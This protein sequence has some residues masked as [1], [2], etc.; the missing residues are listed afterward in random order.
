[1]AERYR[2]RLSGPILDRIDL[3]VPVPRLSAE[4]LAS[5]AP[6]EASADIRER[7]TKARQRQKARF[8][9]ATR[10]NA[11]LSNRELDYFLRAS[12]DAERFLLSS[13]DRL[14]LSSRAFFRIKKVARTIADLASSDTVTPEHVAEAVGYRER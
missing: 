14:K 12:P 7:V 13:V 8:G 2:G 3:F 9:D 11:T 6:G 10:T 5:K 1:M 4:E